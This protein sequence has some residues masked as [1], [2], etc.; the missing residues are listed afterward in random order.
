MGIGFGKARCL[1]GT[2][3]FKTA[4]DG[5]DLDNWSRYIILRL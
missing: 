3:S 4:E 5:R 1:W 2:S